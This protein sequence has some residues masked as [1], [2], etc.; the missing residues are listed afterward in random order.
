M[1]TKTTPAPPAAAVAADAHW[2][3]TQER[4]RAR[5][6]PTAKLTI[7]DD[8]DVKKG[9]EV[10]RYTLRRL[11]DQAK[12]SP[13]DKAAQAA[14]VS[15]RA[16]LEAAQAA[17]DEVAIVL[18]FRALPRKAFE[19]LKRAHPATEE[20]A[21]DDLEF[22]VDSL[23]PELVSASSVDGITVEDAR[24]YLDTWGEAEAAELF[25]TAWGVQQTTRMDLGKG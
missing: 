10:A 6:R 15:A 8:L 1:P 7:C 12:E 21:E 13:D 24:D 9:L 22:D 2:A 4:L 17:F 20:Q 3:A 14:V 25:G 5:T 19:A 11:E 23:G 16:D 18:T